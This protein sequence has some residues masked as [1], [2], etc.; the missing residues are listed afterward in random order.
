MFVASGIDDV[1]NGV[2]GKPVGLASAAGKAWVNDDAKAMFLISSAM[3]YTQLECLLSCASSKEMW[4]KLCRIHEQ[5]SASKRLLLT[6]KFHGYEMSTYWGLCR[7]G[8]YHYG[9]GTR[10]INGKI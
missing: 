7:I 6:Q 3:E 9:Q 8:S 10:G 2:R 1:V 4:D 5:K